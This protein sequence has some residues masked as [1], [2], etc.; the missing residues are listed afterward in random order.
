MIETAANVCLLFL[1]GA[2]LLCGWR[3]VR[4]PTLPDRVVAAD[5]ISIN[6]IA[7]IV[8]YSIREHTSIYFDA[9]LVLSV[10]AFV[11]TLTMA[12]Y[13]ARGDMIFDE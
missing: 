11:G 12:K 1:L 4:G 2:V 3:L 5:T 8:I 10:L 9:V 6:V 13:L 7:M